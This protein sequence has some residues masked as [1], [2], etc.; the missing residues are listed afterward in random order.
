MT[1]VACGLCPWVK[2]WSTEEVARAAGVWH[3]YEEH[4]QEF[5]ATLG[6]RRPPRDPR[7]REMGVLLRG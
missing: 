4:R 3:V 7:P 2:S 6:E 1:P 5:Y